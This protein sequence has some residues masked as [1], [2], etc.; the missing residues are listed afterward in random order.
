MDH[1]F[2]HWCL[3]WNK[4]RNISDPLDKVKF[5]NFGFS[6]KEL[7]KRRQVVNINFA[8]TPEGFLRDITAKTP[9]GGPSDDSKRIYFGLEGFLGSASGAN[10]PSL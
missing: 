6:L 3:G 1:I 10:F 4:K 5:F 2:H 8:V 7:T 9:V